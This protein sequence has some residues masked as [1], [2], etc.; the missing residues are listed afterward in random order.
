MENKKQPRPTAT[1]ILRARVAAI[2]KDEHWAPELRA[3]HRANEK[4]LNKKG[5]PQ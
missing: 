5:K 1:T 4:F 3:A 2:P